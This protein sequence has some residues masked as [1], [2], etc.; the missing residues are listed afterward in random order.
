MFI[1]VGKSLGAKTQTEA[2]ATGWLHRSHRATIIKSHLNWNNKRQPSFGIEKSF[3]SEDG[4]YNKFNIYNY[5]FIHFAARPW[6]LWELHKTNF[7][8]YRKQCLYYI[9]PVSYWFP[10]SG[11][12]RHIW[13]ISV[14]H[15]CLTS[16]SENKI[17]WFNNSWS[18]IE[19][20]ILSYTI[21]SYWT[22]LANINR[23]SKSG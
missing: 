5:I 2:A 7:I 16:K 18:E 8:G 6:Y 12:L 4:L 13:G 3:G 10:S 11:I 23:I 20:N 14:V 9:L 19:I 15:V 22:K 17:Q 21:T 1:L